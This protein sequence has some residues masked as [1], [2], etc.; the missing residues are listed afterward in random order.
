MN[1]DRTEILES[2]FNLRDILTR[3]PADVVRSL[4]E[5]DEVRQTLN[6]IFTG[7]CEN[8]YNNWSPPETH[9]N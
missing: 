2:F 9:R 7:Q 5:A 4:H 8:V 3:V 1:N 6:A